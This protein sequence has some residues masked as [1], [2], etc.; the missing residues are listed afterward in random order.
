MTQSTLR[1]A[2]SLGLLGWSVRLHKWISLAVGLQ[3][4]LWVLGGL[5]MTVLPIGIVRGEH[6]APPP[7][8]AGLS[9]AGLVPLSE[10][11]RVAGFDP[12]KAELRQTPRGAVWVLSRSK[13]EPVV[14]DAGTARPLKYAANQGQTTG[15]SVGNRQT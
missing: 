11:V 8:S 9:V 12:V 5:V 7:P 3:V 1:P 13:G 4:L 2:P 14:L 10:A 15:G 6:H